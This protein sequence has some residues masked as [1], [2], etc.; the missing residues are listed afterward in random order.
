MVP[1][2]D[3]ERTDDPVY[4]ARLRRLTWPIVLATGL[5]VAAGLSGAAATAGLA[6]FLA[7]AIDEMKGSF[8]GIGWIA[9]PAAVLGLSLVSFAFGA[10]FTV[11]REHLA[12]GWE[13]GRRH[14]LVAAYAGARFG[15]HQKYSGP[16]L[17]VAN[18]Q[19]GQASSTIASL[20]GL[21][22]S[23]VGTAIYLA[24]ALLA[25]WQISLLALAAGGVLVLGLRIISVQ[26]RR[27][28]RRSAAMSVDIGDALGEMSVT[29]RE[30]HLLDRWDEAVQSTDEQIEE[31]RGLRFKAR[32]LATMVGPIFTL[33]TALVGLAVGLVSQQSST[34]NLP[35]LA[36]AG[37]LLIRALG[38]AQASQT[39][40]QQYNDANPYVERVLKLIAALRSLARPPGRTADGENLP[41]SARNVSLSHGN[42]EV[43]HNLHL[44]FEGT[45]GIAIVG[46]SGSG[47]STTLTALSGLIRPSAGAIDLG[48]TCLEDLDRREL[49]RRVGLLPQDPRLLQASLRHNVL[50]ADMSA[51]DEELLQ[52]LKDLGLEATI[53]G[54]PDGLHTE[55]GRSGEGFS[56][57]ELQRLGLARLVANQPDVWLLDEPTSALDRTNADVVERKIIEAMSTRLVILVTHR[58]ELLRHCREVVMMHDGRLVDS[59]A[60]Q[61]V[62]VRQEFVASMVRHDRDRVMEGEQR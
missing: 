17:T 48:D 29:S 27:L 28:I 26:T 50:R 1:M 4:D 58:P 40:Y 5:A 52:I 24:A 9:N 25:S 45:G 8:G 31:V 39:L 12:A 23:I 11:L 44:T 49:G 54:F 34:V 19:I 56:G 47:K 7:T 35:S 16:T 41:L 62:V 21:I 38:A 36:A 15:A 53:A 37:L 60:L 18:E 51:T 22:N 61:D 6:A 33:G 3:R 59:G 13:S 55:M 10:A 46:E 14:D 32:T 43:V 42:D 30:L 20:I 57:G 2:T